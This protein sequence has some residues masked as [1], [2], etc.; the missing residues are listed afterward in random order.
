VRLIPVP[1]EIPAQA[2]AMLAS[3]EADAF[4]HVVPMLAI[5]QGSLPGSRLLP[6]SYYDVPIAIGFAKGLPP[7]A[8]EF[9]NAFV[10]DVKASGFVAQA[11]ARMGESARGLV[12]A[13]GCD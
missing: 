12:V 11:I 3:G 6:G 4:S 9:C 5:V 7:A 13:G 8:A 10:A 2:I 1:A